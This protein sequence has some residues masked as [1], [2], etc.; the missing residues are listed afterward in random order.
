MRNHRYE[1]QPLLHTIRLLQ[2]EPAARAYSDRGST[3]RFCSAE[4]W[5]AKKIRSDIEIVSRIGQRGTLLVDRLHELAHRPHKAGDGAAHVITGLDKDIAVSH[6]VR[7]I[8]RD[9]ADLFGPIVSA[10]FY[11]VPLPARAGVPAVI[12]ADRAFFRPHPER[13]LV[14]K[15]LV[16]V[17]FEV[18]RHRAA[19]ELQLPHGYVVA[20]GAID[21][22]RRAPRKPADGVNG[23]DLP[24]QNDAVGAEVELRAFVRDVRQ[25][26]ERRLSEPLRRQELLGRVDRRIEAQVLIDG[27]RNP[28]F[29]GDIDHLLRGLE[30][31][32]H[33]L[34]HQDRFA[35]LGRI[36]QDLDA[37]RHVQVIDRAVDDLDVVALHDLAV[38]LVHV[39][40]SVQRGQF[41]AAGVDVRRGHHTISRQA[42]C[43]QML[44]AY[45]VGVADDRDAIVE[46]VGFERRPEGGPLKTGE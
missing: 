7:E 41:P 12:G 39:R 16:V 22:D 46:L 35:G 24:L 1:Q 5:P 11:Q 10:N 45:D 29:F 27:V 8:I 32:R 37:G 25:V 4:S 3:G 6:F 13:R 30:I 14:M 9:P 23:V 26:N 40:N 17:V 15:I 33:G 28:V 44:G 19:R 21:R 2:K 34:L 38:I 36:L 20:V 43:G 42:V 18:V 31:H